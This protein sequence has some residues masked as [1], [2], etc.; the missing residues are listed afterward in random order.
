LV[1]LVV[2]A[3][4]AVENWELAYIEK[5][6]KRVEGGRVVDVRDVEYGEVVK[7]VV[8]VVVVAGAE[9]YNLLGLPV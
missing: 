6:R 9:I 7:E 4:V 5:V 3:E 2:V 8:V 1:C